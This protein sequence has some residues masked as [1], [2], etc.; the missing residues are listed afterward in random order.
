MALRVLLVLLLTIVAVVGVLHVSPVQRAVLQ[1]TLA[2]VLPP[3]LQVTLGGS[4]GSP[5]R[6][7]TLTDVRASTPGD[8]T[9]LAVDTLRVEYDL[10]SV[11]GVLHVRK[12]EAGDLSFQLG[13][14]ADSSLVLP[15]F[16]ESDTTTFPFN[17][18][19]VEVQRISGSVVQ[20]DDVLWTLDDG[21]LDLPVL[22]RD[23][24][25]FAVT[26][27]ALDLAFTYPGVTDAG[28]VAAR[29]ELGRDGAFSAA[30][31]GSA[32]G[33][34]LDLDISGRLPDSSGLALDLDV[35]GHVGF[36]DLQ[37]FVATL[38]DDGRL[39]VEAD[40]HVGADSLRARVVLDTGAGGRVEVR[41]DGSASASGP[42]QVLPRN[43]NILVE[44]EDFRPDALGSDFP[45]QTLLN[46][47]ADA[48]LALGDTWEETMGRVDVTLGPGSLLGRRVGAGS[49]FAERADSTISWSGTVRAAGALL[50][51][52]GAWQMG[53]DRLRGT[54]HVEDLT[55]EGLDLSSPVPFTGGLS[56]TFRGTES[57]SN[58][59]A[60]VELL[61]MTV[62]GCP[63]TSRNLRM[64]LQMPA[65]STSST[66]T[67]IEGGLD[68]C[69][70]TLADLDIHA[71]NTRVQGRVRTG[72]AP[73]HELLTLADSTYLP[74]EITFDLTPDGPV[75]ADGRFTDVQGGGAVLDSL[76]F[77]ATG[78]LDALSIEAEADRLDG[79]ARTR[80]QWRSLD[81]RVNLTALEFQA[82][83]VASVLRMPDQ[84]IILSGTGSGVMTGS[85]GRL[86]LMLGGSHLNDVAFSV[87]DLDIRMAADSMTA[88]IRARGDSAHTGT[89]A[90]LTAGW[91]PSQ[92]SLIT[93]SGIFGGLDV[94]AILALEGQSSDL[95]GDLDVR[96]RLQNGVPELDGHV[97]LAAG[98]RLN[99]FRVT[100]A[101]LNL[102]L[103]D[104]ASSGKLV[105][106]DTNGGI[107]GS[108]G[109][110]EGR[111][112]A[113]M[114]AHHLDIA[115]LLDPRAS[116][117]TLSAT[118]EANIQLA[119]GTWTDIVAT[120]DSLRGSWDA[121]RVDDG[122]FGVH[123]DRTSVRVDSLRLSGTD[124][125]LDGRGSFAQESSDFTLRA[126]VPAAIMQLPGLKE[127]G[128]AFV[129]LGA[130]VRVNG[131]LAQ[132]RVVAD[133]TAGGLRNE[134]FYASEITG[135]F[136]AEFGDS[137]APD[138]DPPVPDSPVD[139][140]PVFPALLPSFAELTVESSVLD[141]PALSMQSATVRV[142][143]DGLDV[144]GDAEIQLAENKHIGV[145]AIVTPDDEPM[146]ITIDRFD[147]R[148][149][150]DTWA[151]SA[152]ARLTL[153]D[154]PSLSALRLTSGDQVISATSLLQGSEQ[155]HFVTVNQVQLA[156]L[157]SLLDFPG[158]GGTTSGEFSLSMA[159]DSLS[160][161]GTLT[162]DLTAFGEPAGQSTA[163]LTLLNGDV[164]LDARLTHP[165]GGE[166]TAAGR[167]PLGSP[168]GTVDFQV[169][170]D[171]YPIGW[172]RV[173]IDPLLV[174]DLRG[175]LSGNV[176]VTGTGNAPAWQ[177]TL[178]LRDGRIG[179]PELGKRRGLRYD[180]LEADLSFRADSILVDRMVAQ[181]GNGRVEASG[182]IAMTDLQLG[183]VDIAFSANDFLAVDNANYRTVISGSGQLTGSTD[184][185]RLQGDIEVVS[186]DFY[187]TDETTAG[188][189]EAV[190]LSDADLLTLRERF[191]MRISAED[192]TAFDFYRVLAIE[193]LTI[194]MQR[195]T[196]VRSKSN[197]EMDIQISG[198]LDVD[199]ARN[200]DPDVFGNIEVLP[201]RSRIQQ[202][203]RRFDIERGTLTFNGP[204]G[205]PIMDLQA[206]YDVPSRTAGGSEVV[207]RLNVSG[208]PDDLE[209]TFDSDPAMELAD[210]VSYIA[211]GRPASSSFQL[212]SQTDN[213]L[214]SA[215]GLAM[216]PLTDLVENM[217]GAGL[218]LDVIEIAHTG[219]Q[220][221]TLTAGK[222]VSP[223]LYVSVSQ[224]IA[225]SSS[226][227]S[228]T[229][230]GENETQ[231]AVEYEIIQQL[232]ITLINR[233]TIL[234]VNLRWEY[235]F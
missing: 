200:A 224:P 180:G 57:L 56:A 19:R 63:V 195:D 5:L 58:W 225:L 167:L 16:P 54:V 91:Y 2:R 29:A 27:R 230:G 183:S 220:G 25:G 212:G 199:K 106:E 96:G 35:A 223:R 206:S 207:I 198:R 127:T 3:D 229:T 181:S 165:Q 71:S 59:T 233:G 36:A 157:A 61:D 173:F 83:D 41:M 6:G 130:T 134:S 154:T 114:R 115:A 66:T 92:D 53:E 209:V 42:A 121:F 189:Y 184:R 132:R 15:T 152:P 234:R 109:L 7:L 11:F 219:T 9:W 75:R 149:N 67:H 80:L 108:F 33:S 40:A 98:S 38:R 160:V 37:P 131:P 222:Y 88:D 151:L 142:A 203:G 141:V 190:T 94:G 201:E 93:A 79:T 144:S 192:T 62:G 191:G 26:L 31:R 13:R 86:E 20:A 69:A 51:T 76:T 133:L 103:E 46:A 175:A 82:L 194:R 110:N 155:R 10:L 179:L 137:G 128:L 70:Q 118:V 125:Q 140:R 162:S 14:R 232:L 95:G 39:D 104:G 146:V 90:D 123:L 211:T 205:A 216:G 170:A 210:I 156:P 44:L 48:A 97:S 138:P 147:A 213:Y 193:D 221:L 116:S 226:S 197:P 81:N 188:A 18:E 49:A 107:T 126:D 204:I 100:T 1:G 129:T 120:G 235:A 105:L 112:Y 72:R 22:A 24:G 143:W 74:G 187:L 77:Q 166:L 68:A 176:R 228:S 185:P 196:W 87:L 34:I 158:L 55:P 30:L 177:G 163:R 60:T 178:Q 117:S 164:V 28:Y 139:L 208:S 136:L 215:A 101:E 73:L 65:P 153:G 102:R 135:R 113:N 8:S 148:L 50:R 172:T 182:G 174:D 169:G 186:A 231:V 84:S 78:T 111:M 218:G 89:T 202:F 159:G 145:S 45:E 161:Q 99:A 17:L 85:N 122:A 52:D 21:H 64:R 4:S 23:S 227:E 171:A 47:R 217:A 124:L 168:E 150:G 214:Q 43:V 12:I 119:E 32:P